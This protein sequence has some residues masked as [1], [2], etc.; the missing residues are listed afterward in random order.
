[1][2]YTEEF[3]ADPAS[4]CE[5][6]LQGLQGGQGA[7]GGLSGGPAML[8][9]KPFAFE[10]VL[11]EWVRFRKPGE[12]RVYVVSR[13]VSRIEDPGRSDYYLR[14]STRAARRWSSCPMS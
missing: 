1:M 2:N 3:I 5:D 10:R 14:G 8:S 6:P 7:M 4:L 13:R 12:Y 9:E 11:N